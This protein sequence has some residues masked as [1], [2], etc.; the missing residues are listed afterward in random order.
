[1]PS[2]LRLGAEPGPDEKVEGLKQ[3]PPL[4]TGTLAV[5]EA[6]VPSVRHDSPT[7][8]ECECEPE[9]VRTSRDHAPKDAYS[10]M[11]RSSVAESGSPQDVGGEDD[12]AEEVVGEAEEGAPKA[13]LWRRFLGGAASHP[14]E[15][16]EADG[17]SVEDAAGDEEHAEVDN[18]EGVAGD[19]EEVAD[20]ELE[21]DDTTDAEA[22]VGGL[23]AA[24]FFAG[25]MAAGLA[26]AAGLLATGHAFE[27]LP[28]QA[29]AGQLG[30]EVSGIPF[31]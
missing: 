18:V 8:T 26:L 6:V 30:D 5:E 15:E 7:T 9:P 28:G 16:E 11:A 10:P 14:D 1:V 19:D 22:K 29:S 27:L 31:S 12:E 23:W 13:P 25:A 2:P 21:L 3:T 20:S 24:L 4:P 17:D